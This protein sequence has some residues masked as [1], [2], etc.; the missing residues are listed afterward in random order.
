MGDVRAD[1]EQAGHEVRVVS[2]G[3]SLTARYLTA[4]DGITEIRP[5]TY[6]YNDLRTLGCWSCPAE[7]IAV[8]MLATVVS[9]GDGGARVT[10]DAGSK[11]L[12]TTMD[13]VYGYGHL[14]GR[15]DATV[16]RLSE[17]HGVLSVAGPPP[18]VGDVVRILP[19]HVCVWSDL[20]PEVYGTR[21]GEIV[22][23]VRIVQHPVAQFPACRACP[24][25][26]P[27]P[28]R[29]HQGRRRSAGVPG[30]GWRSGR[31][32]RRPRP[33]ARSRPRSPGPFQ[34]KFFPNDPGHDS[35]PGPVRA[36]R[37]GTTRPA[38]AARR[39]RRP[40]GPSAAGRAR[41]AGGPPRRRSRRS[42][43]R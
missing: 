39:D 28:A 8:T 4:A 37:P 32:R 11:T 13:P 1:L 43:S 19:V 29:D 7:Q 21:N 36:P 30:P 23:Q 34:K 14:A 24:R 17:E 25:P 33:A 42:A 10:M 16:T 40:A 27:A 9:T 41:P 26:W 31:G 6:I 12:T 15:P 18:A 5:G 2:A 22:D 38:T 20:Q 35:I 3:S